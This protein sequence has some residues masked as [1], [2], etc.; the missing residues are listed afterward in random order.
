MATRGTAPVVK[1]SIFVPGVGQHDNIGD[2]MLRRPLLD[3]LRPLGE[4][5]VYVG[6]AP[7]GYTQGLDLHDED[8]VYE[9]FPSWYAAALGAA[10]RGRTHYAFKPGEIQLTFSGLKEHVVMTPVA[11]LIR[12]RHGRVVR[13]GAGAMNFAPLPRLLMRPSLALSQ[14]CIWRDQDTAS[15]LGGEAMP[16]LA[17]SEG[18]PVDELRS[19]AE[20]SRLVISMRYDRPAISSAWIEGVRSYAAAQGLEVWTATQVKRDSATSRT[21]AGHFGAKVLDWDGNDPAA[22]E[23]KLR[24]LYRSAAVVVSDRLHVLISSFTHGAVPVALLTDS[25]T[26]IE[27]HF[28]AIGVT[29]VATRCVDLDAQRIRE[30]IA[31]SCAR[32]PRALAELSRARSDLRAVRERL[33]TFLASAGPDAKAAKPGGPA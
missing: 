1:H 23:L 30:S 31:E 32:Q 4:L 13:I 3:W 7:T 24:E 20:R 27:R 2:I 18:D 17:F 8:T 14:L 25:S 9:S 21:I 29:G 12:L 5:H 16:D 6:R 26:K 22:Q 33:A 15:Y 28:R 19:P 11:A 10:A